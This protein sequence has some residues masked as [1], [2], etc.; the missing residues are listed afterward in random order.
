MGNNSEELKVLKSDSREADLTQRITRTASRF[1]HRALDFSDHGMHLMESDVDYNDFLTL[2]E[3][4]NEFWMSNSDFAMNHLMQ[5]AM[6]NLLDRRSARTVGFNVVLN[7]EGV[8]ADAS[9]GYIIL[10]PF[11]PLVAVSMFSGTEH[12]AMASVVVDAR[13]GKIL[14]RQTYSYNVADHPDMLDAMLHD[15]YDQGLTPRKKEP[16][17]FMG[18]RF[19]LVG[20]FNLGLAGSQTFDAGHILALT[21]WAS[22][23]FAATRNYSFALWGRYHKGYE[24]IYST[25]PEEYFDAQGRYHYTTHRIQSSHN[26]LTIGADCRKYFRSEFAPL[27]IYWS[28]GPHMVHF[29]PLDGSASSNTFGIHAGLGRNY[30]FFHR[31]LLNYEVTYAYTYGVNKSIDFDFSGEYK[32]YLHYADAV[33][34][35]MVTFRLGLGILPF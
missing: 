30:I 5:P 26:M 18:R 32:K 12:T 27:G 20:G 35:N 15:S 16:K 34:A 8:K 13:E 23:E 17:G 9:P 7:V 25:Y 24:D 4:A 14:S 22:V 1:G 6:D 10:I 31:L 2:C 28:I 33:V 21:P 29:M 19:D 11:A 3:W